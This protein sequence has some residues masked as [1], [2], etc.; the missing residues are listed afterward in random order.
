MAK[1]MSGVEKENYWELQIDFVSQTNWQTVIK[2]RKS[3]H[4][5]CFTQLSTEPHTVRY[6]S[7]CLLTLI[8]CSLFSRLSLSDSDSD[9]SADSC[10]P[11]REPPP[12][13]KLPAANNKVLNPTCPCK[14][15]F[16]QCWF[17]HH[18]QS[19]MLV[20]ACTDASLFHFLHQRG[21]FS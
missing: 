3:R 8:L 5:L 11:S 4:H 7:H 13:Q 2:N 18:V 9:N 21:N 14:I 6:F 16:H 17:L 1:V 15:A 19:M 10:L 12:G 20:L